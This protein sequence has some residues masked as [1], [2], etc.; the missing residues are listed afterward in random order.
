MEGKIRQMTDEGAIV[1]ASVE[2]TNGMVPFPEPVFVFGISRKIYVDGD[3][4]QGT[5]WLAGNHRIATKT[6][7]AFSTD[8]EDA[9]ERIWNEPKPQPAPAEPEALTKPLP[10]P[11]IGGDPIETFKALSA[12]LPKSS[13]RKSNATEYRISD[14][15]FDVKKTGVLALLEGL[16]RCNMLGIIEKPIHSSRAHFRGEIS[17][18]IEAVLC[19]RSCAYKRGTH[20]V[21]RAGHATSLR[22]AETADS[23]TGGGGSEAVC[24]RGGSGRKL[25]WRKKGAWKTWTRSQRQDPG[26]RLAQAWRKGLHRNRRQLL[27]ARTD[28]DCEGTGAFAID[29]LHRRME[30][31]R[32]P[33]PG[34][35]QTP[36][37]P[38]SP[39]PVRPR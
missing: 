28:A 24:G 17:G 27:P 5:V 1:L 8:K 16:K 19:G 12:T 3:P 18:D 35:L 13:L 9:I 15:A 38:S 34:W 32:R 36:P 39:K 30:V 31:L 25:L 11:S 7:R 20:W 26:N 2:R 6:L 10:N 4:Y 29:R 14:T 33:C 22:Q 21:E 23:G 37:H